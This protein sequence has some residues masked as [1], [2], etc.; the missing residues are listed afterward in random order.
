MTNN[1][2]LTSCVGH[3]VARSTFQE[4]AGATLP[5][6][7]VRKEGIMVAEQLLRDPALFSRVKGVEPA[8]L[9]LID[10]YLTQ[11]GYQSVESQHLQWRSLLVPLLLRYCLE[12]DGSQSGEC[13]SVWDARNVDV[14]RNHLRP[15]CWGCQEHPRSDFREVRRSYQ[16][17]SLW[18][19]GPY[20]SPSKLLQYS[21]CSSHPT[22]PGLMKKLQH[23]SA[24]ESPSWPW[25]SLLVGAVG[26]AEAEPGTQHLI[27]APRARTAARR[28][29]GL[30]VYGG[31]MWFVCWGSRLIR[32]GFG[33]EH[34]WAFN[35]TMHPSCTASSNYS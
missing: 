5:L 9:E 17:A 35:V 28:G 1:L 19:N 13:F 33:L 8:P 4:A 30:E 18:A 20:K 22:S 26:T 34:L 7:A 29:L 21:S 6:L 12:L 3:P 24:F 14:L 25:R 16:P 32:L 31:L 23:S 11:L 2:K 10:E 27:A 15:A